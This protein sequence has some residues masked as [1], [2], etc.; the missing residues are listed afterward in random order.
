MGVSLVVRLNKKAYEA[1]RFT[2]LGI[3]HLD[4]YFLDGSTPSDVKIIIHII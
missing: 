3:K 1:N 2:K 4:L